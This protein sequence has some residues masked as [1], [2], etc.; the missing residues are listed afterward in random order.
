MR[1]L[2][3]LL[4]S[5]LYPKED[6]ASLLTKATVLLEAERAAYKKQATRKAID[7]MRRQDARG[8]ET[9]KI[10]NQVF[11]ETLRPMIYDQVYDWCTVTIDGREYDLEGQIIDRDFDRDKETTRRRLITMYVGSEYERYVTSKDGE[12]WLPIRYVPR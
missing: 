6:Y 1:A 2:V 5:R 10:C 7:E 8:E 12:H 3:F 4:L 11:R 9:R